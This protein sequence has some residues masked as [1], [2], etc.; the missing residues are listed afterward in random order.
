MVINKRVQATRPG[1]Y[2]WI[3]F[4]LIFGLMFSDYLSR[5][6]MNA[7]FPFLKAEWALTDT[8][9]GALVSVVA[10]TVGVMS[11]PISLVADRVGRVRAATVMAI[12]WGLA[13]IA[14]GLSGNFLMMFVARAFVGL[15]EAAYGSAGGAILVSIFPARMHAMVMGT[16]LAA[17]LF[18]SVLG[19]TLGGLIA[20]Q[21]GWPMAFIVV[22]AGGLVLAV[23]F[24]LVVREPVTA[25]GVKEPPLPLRQIGRELFT[26]RT[27]I[28]TYLG[29]GLSMFIQGAFVAWMPSYLNRYHDMDPAGAALG[30]GV[31]ILAAGVGMMGGGALVDRLSLK[32]PRNRLRLPAL[33]LLGSA[34]CL[35]VAFSLSPGLPQLVMIGLG[36][37][38]GAGFSGP[39]GA[40]VADVT[41]ASIHATV[42]ATLTL[43]NNILGLAPG[44]VLTGWVADQTS[45]LTA[46][47]LVPLIAVLAAVAFAVGSMFYVQDRVRLHGNASI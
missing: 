32:D 6:V 3:A 21:W 31:L 26:T 14:C 27:A 41:H 37:M 22:G 20:Q 39:A 40:V 30:A 28:C 23:V 43:G 10:L 33:Y 16:F 17:A 44:P 2:A 42:L 1:L 45:L 4:T 47:Q 36:L 8:Q 34:L 5:Q 7:V 11:F 9:L 38:I 13:T 35:T 12:V 46:L 15:G 25:S 29:S 19:V 18:G 24:P